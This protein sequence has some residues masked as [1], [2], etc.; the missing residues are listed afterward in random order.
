MPAAD[1]EPSSIRGFVALNFSGPLR[2]TLSGVIARL[3]RGAPP[4]TVKWVDAETIHLTL[5]FLGDVPTDRIRGIVEVLNAS[6]R[7]QPA[8]QFTACG[9]GAFPSLRKPRVVWAGVDEEGGE[10]IRRLQAAVE[11]ALT[12]LGY[13]SEARPFS[14]HIT[15]GRVRREAGPRDLGRLGEVVAA[16][17]APA[18][19]VE[20]VGAVY[21]M[22]S[23]LRPSGPLYTPLSEARLTGTVE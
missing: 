18:L 2:Q 4:G 9:L 14:P 6:V 3:V 11:A 17:P 20:T 21:L 19:G 16:Q 7:S 23:E 5:K 10:K 1:H 22:K 12:P 15:L 8:F 13:P